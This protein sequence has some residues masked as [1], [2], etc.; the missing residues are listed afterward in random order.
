MKAYEI[1]AE[2]EDTAANGFLPF[3]S[4]KKVHKTVF[5]DVET[6]DYEWRR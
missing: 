1:Y 6:V 4:R 2:E 5:A 3:S